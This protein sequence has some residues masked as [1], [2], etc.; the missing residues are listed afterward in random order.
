MLHRIAFSVAGGIKKLLHRNVDLADIPIAE[1][2]LATEL[3]IEGK[4]VSP[5]G[6]LVDSEFDREIPDRIAA[7]FFIDGSFE[8]LAGFRLGIVGGHELDD[9][10][11]VHLH[12]EI[13][14]V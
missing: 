1:I 9:G 10:V 7:T 13:D 6:G 8:S 12:E 4:A 11:N 3:E 2:P 5:S 14:V